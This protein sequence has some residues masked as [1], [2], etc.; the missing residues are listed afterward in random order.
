MKAAVRIAPDDPEL[1][2]TLCILLGHERLWR[3]AQRALF[4]LESPPPETIEQIVVAMRRSR[5]TLAM[6]S[7]V[8]RLDPHN[9]YARSVMTKRLVPSIRSFNDLRNQFDGEMYQDEFGDFDA[10]LRAMGA[11]GQDLVAELIKIVR[12]E[13]HA[14]PASPLRPLRASGWEIEGRK[15]PN[16]RSDNLAEQRSE[17]EWRRGLSDY[18]CQLAIGA[19]GAIGPTASEAIPLLMEVLGTAQRGSRPELSVKEALRRIGAAA[20]PALEKAVD[21]DNPRLRARAVGILAAFPDALPTVIHA[22]DDERAS[23]RLAAVQ[24]I[25]KLGASAGQARPALQLRLDDEYV[26]VREAAKQALESLP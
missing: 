25:A 26:A 8:L 10:A 14:V 24:A 5:P 17:V 3:G 4:L 18:K 20:V 22:L 12:T 2:P 6:A 13:Y 1:V 19:L 7:L 9:E 11:E 21:G 23:V 15:R 16:E